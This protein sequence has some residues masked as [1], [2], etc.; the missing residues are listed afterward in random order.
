MLRIVTRVLQLGATME[1]VYF[2]WFDILLLFHSDKFNF[3]YLKII[4]QKIIIYFYYLKT[5]IGFTYV[6]ANY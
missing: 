2:I 6:D 4:I 5:F 3:Y 1:P